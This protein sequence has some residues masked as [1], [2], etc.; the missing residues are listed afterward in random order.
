MIQPRF[1]GNGVIIDALDV[2]CVQ[3]TRDLFTIAN[4]LYLQITLY[5]PPPPKRSP[6][7]ATIDCGGG[8]LIAAYCSF[9]D[10]ERMKGRVGLVG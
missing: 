9:I 4:F 3:L 6:N 1:Q 10:P 5:L 7:G 8:H 2:L